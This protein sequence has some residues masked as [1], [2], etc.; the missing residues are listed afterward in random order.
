MGIG[1][2]HSVRGGGTGVRCAGGSHGIWTSRLPA[3]FANALGRDQP[4]RR[5]RSSCWPQHTEP[6]L[7][8]GFWP[9]ML[10][11]IFIVLSTL[12]L[13][14][15][16]SLWTGRRCRRRAVCARLLAAAAQPVGKP[17]RR[18][19][20][21]YHLSRSACCCWPASSR[22]DR[23]AAACAGSSRTRS[24]PRRR[25]TG[26]PTC[27][28]SMF[29]RPWSTSC[30]DAGRSAE[31]DAH[32][33]RAVPRHPRLH[34]HDPH[35]RGRRDGGAA[36]RLLRRDDRRSSTVTT[37][38]STSSWATASWRCS[39]R[40]SPIP[41]AAANAL[42]AGRD[43]LEAVDAWN[44]AR[45][46]QALRVGIGIHIGEAV[47]GTIGSPRRK[48]YT[49]IGDTVNLAARLEQ[50]TKETGAR[51]LVSGCARA[52]VARSTARRSRRRCRS[53]ATAN[54]SRLEAGMIWYFAYGSNM[55]PARLV[56]ERLK[57]SGRRDGR[58]HRRSAR[59]LAARLQ[60]ASRVRPPAR[61]PA[62]SCEAPGAVVHGTLNE[63]P[64]AGFEV[65]DHLG[66]RG[67]RPLRRVGRCRCCAPTRASKSKPS[68]M[69]RS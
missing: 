59:R 31:R 15:W 33:L 27:S 34:R 4:A 10:Y 66:R 63:M 13:D 45:P 64:D 41:S 47:T 56:D 42:A 5:R 46:A 39:V 19:A 69:S 25:A 37:A 3:R 17:R 61:R 68:P 52:A 29:R 48:E 49:V 58:T 62:T 12:R 6:Q 54:R 8:F 7:V 67:R 32:R 1:S 65:L 35:A 2:V 24:P 60:Q 44:C 16:L 43:M 57:P 55:N 22:G 28:A 40:R 9:P 26:S 21:I 14:F 18:N 38:S 20:L 11:F 36:Q 53:A 23:R 51:L 50:L 30:C